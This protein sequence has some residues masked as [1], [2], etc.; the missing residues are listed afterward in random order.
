MSVWQIGSVAECTVLAAPVY[1]RTGTWSA[2]PAFSGQLAPGAAQ[3]FCFRSIL[4][5]NV[6]SSQPGASVTPELTVTAR[7]GGWSAVAIA[8]TTQRTPNLA[9]IGC[10]QQGTTAALDWLNPASSNCGLYVNGIEVAKTKKAQSPYLFGA[11]ELA[12]AGIVSPGVVT[13]EVRQLGQGTVLFTRTITVVLL[14]T[15]LE[16]RC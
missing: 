10:T 7:I 16:L 15:Q 5:P 2:A 13:V 11:D 1:A 8:S 14:G 9:G 3:L 12:A 6:L 4:D